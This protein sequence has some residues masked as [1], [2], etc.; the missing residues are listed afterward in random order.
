MAKLNDFKKNV[1]AV[2]DQITD[3][4]AK[5]QVNKTSSEKDEKSLGYLRDPCS[6]SKSLGH[7][8]LCIL[9]SGRKLL[10]SMS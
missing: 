3:L 10:S 5:L 2:Y 7:A 4:S 1:D 9:S 6:P 8:G